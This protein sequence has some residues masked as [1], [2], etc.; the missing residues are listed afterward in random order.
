MNS[1]MDGALAAG[2]C[3]SNMS[4]NVQTGLANA[5]SAATAE[6]LEIQ[7]GKSNVL[8]NLQKQMTSAARQVCSVAGS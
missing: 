7:S 4:T 6:M 3:V 2:N 5:N 8:K 1:A